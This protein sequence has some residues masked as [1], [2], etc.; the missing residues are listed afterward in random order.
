MARAN[1]AKHPDTISS[2]RRRGVLTGTIAALLADA[3]R[4]RSSGTGW[5]GRFIP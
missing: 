2:P 3:H 1:G 4:R 5:C